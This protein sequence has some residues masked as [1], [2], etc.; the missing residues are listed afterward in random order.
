[1][2]EDP[3]VDTV[4]E[5]PVVV[6]E[7][8]MRSPDK[9]HVEHGDRPG[10]T[11]ILGRRCLSSDAIQRDQSQYVEISLNKGAELT[12]TNLG[13]LRTM[14]REPKEL[15]AGKVELLPDS[16]VHVKFK[17]DGAA[18]SIDGEVLLIS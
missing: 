7:K 5:P 8:K 3:P 18:G 2:R 1:M 11:H 10:R 14:P 12:L 16:C 6:G 17:V 9:V 15:G 13:L 4:A